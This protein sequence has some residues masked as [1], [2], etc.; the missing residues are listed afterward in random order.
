MDRHH[1]V[2]PM[3]R[4]HESA[5][6]IGTMNRPHESAPWTSPRVGRIAK[7]KGQQASR[8]DRPEVKLV[9]LA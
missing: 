1:E 5:L 3:N 8:N 9:D 6:W 4:P 7:A 2:G